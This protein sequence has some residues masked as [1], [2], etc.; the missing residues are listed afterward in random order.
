MPTVDSIAPF[1]V[2]RRDCSAM[3]FSMAAL[4]LSFFGSL[5]DPFLRAS[6]GRSLTYDWQIH[7]GSL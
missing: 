5:M 7:H 6:P 1:S 4:L 3:L 2:A